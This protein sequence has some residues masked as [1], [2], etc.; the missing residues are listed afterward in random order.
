M[1]IRTAT[2]LFVAAFVL[3][4]L[5][6]RQISSDDTR[7]AR[8]VPISILREGNIDLH[9]FF[10][11]RTSYPYYLHLAGDR[12]IDSYPPTGPLLAL[13]VYAPLVWSGWFRDDYFL[14]TLC[15]KL[16]A[17]AMTA[18][19]IAFLYIAMSR[20]SPPTCP[21]RKI[22][23]EKDVQAWHRSILVGTCAAA[24]GTS[25]WSTSSQ[26]LYSHAPAALTTAWALCAMAYDRQTLAGVALGLAVW[27][28]PVL[29]IAIP[30]AVACCVWNGQL[31][32][33]LA[34]AM[35]GLLPVLSIAAVYN[36]RFLGHLAGGAP[37]RTRFWMAT[38]G[39]DSLFS[40]SIGEGLAGLLVSPSRGLFVYS[41]IVLLGLVG[42]VASW[43]RRYAPGMCA[44]LIV[45]GVTV[46]YANFVVW[47]G[48]H[49]YGPRYLTDIALLLGL[50]IAI[51]HFS[52]TTQMATNDPGRRKSLRL[53]VAAL[54]AYSVAIQI[55]GVLCHPS[56]WTI[57]KT[58]PYWERLWSIEHSQILTCIREGPR[59]DPGQRWLL[60]TL[61]LLSH[62]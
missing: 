6:G 1:R 55:I 5:N 20:L 21:W 31:R 37:D 46:A 58:P 8:Y 24:F 57:S 35:I 43:R 13:P 32:R 51:G 61:G 38:L 56:S 19:A 12:L 47:W 15:S 4:N 34:R 7:A 40:G 60:E 23:T 62:D 10:G 39:K 27:S 59:L 16:A 54:L 11:T 53:G 33:P 50:L 48:G 17:A 41:P 28:R 9:E 2:A 42:A 36:L 22:D 3:Y 52:L 14:A 44:S 45:V 49:G 30:I 29:A 18:C 26:G 25:L